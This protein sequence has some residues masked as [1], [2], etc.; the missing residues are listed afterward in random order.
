MINTKKNLGIGSLSLFLCVIGILFAFTFNGFKESFGDVV[1]RSIGL[2][3]WS[4]GSEGTHYTIYYSFIFFLSSVF[5]GFMYKEDFG[6]TLGKIVSLIILILFS[7]II[8]FS[9]SI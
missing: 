9:F 2:K 1:I 6:A 3:T 5:T 7:M 8:F 4:R